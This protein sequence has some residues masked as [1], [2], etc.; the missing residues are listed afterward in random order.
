MVLRDAQGL[1][2][3][4]SIEAIAER[5][6]GIKQNL[7]SL[8]TKEYCG[9]CGKNSGIINMDFGAAREIEQEIKKNLGGLSR[10]FGR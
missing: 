5:Y 4:I 8:F 9:I 2:F 3:A 10:L 1:G 6:E 7:S